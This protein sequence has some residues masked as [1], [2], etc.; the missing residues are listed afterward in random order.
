MAGSTARLILP[1]LALLAL[2]PGRSGVAAQAQAVD[3]ALV[4]AL[5]AS[6]SVNPDEFYLQTYGLS[7]AFADP[8]VQDAIARGPS[9]AIAVALVQWSAPDRQTLA[10]GWQ[11]VTRDS[12]PALAETLAN[13]ARYIEGGGTAPGSALAF[14][15]A[16]FERL[17]FPAGRRVIDVSGDGK[18]TSGPDPA[19]L[20]DALVARGLTING[21]AILN[22]ERDVGRYYEDRL[23]GGPGAFVMTANSYDDYLTAIR[24]KLLCEIGNQPLLSLL[25][26]PARP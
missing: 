17:P 24:T 11:R 16:V 10:L 22:E 14:A 19:L 4:L 23:S 21:L 7:L 6:S 25:V 20:R 26:R 12:A 15:G 9:G 3:L 5:D 8:Q 2:I 1:A 13:L 18:A